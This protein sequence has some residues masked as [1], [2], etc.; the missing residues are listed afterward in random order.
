MESQVENS[1]GISFLDDVGWA[2]EGTDLDDVISKLERCSAASLRWASNNA[3]SFET[4]KAEAIHFS[5]RGRHRQCQRG[6]RA[7]DQT[8]CFAREATR[9][10]GIWLDSALTLAE[11]RRWRIDKTARPKPGGGASS[12]RMAF[13]R[14]QRVTF[15]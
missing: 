3:V 12:V 11:N 13:H 9:W 7:G 6:A 1:R 8:V 14:Q 4:P 15:S 10:L 2:V 5:R